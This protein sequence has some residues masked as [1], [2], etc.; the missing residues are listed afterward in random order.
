MPRPPSRLAACLLAALLAGCASRAV[1][2]KPAPVSPADF[3]GWDCDRLDDELDTVQQQAADVAYAVDERA[4]DNILALGIGVTIFWPAI[5]AMRPDGPDA[6]E[7]ARLKGRD[8]ALRTAQRSKGCAPPG[9]ALPPA[10]AAAWPVAIG[11]R[12]VYE[13]RGGR[14]APHEAALKLAALRRDEAEFR[15]ERSAG[16]TVWR[17]DLAGNTVAAPTGA[18]YWHRLLRRELALG[19]VVVGEMGVTGDA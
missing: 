12:L 3:A 4:G 2:V 10:R 11:E 13:E 7:L 18:L 5:L 15:V 19:Q 14:G 16:G 1:D 8:E 9:V 17:Q 6:A